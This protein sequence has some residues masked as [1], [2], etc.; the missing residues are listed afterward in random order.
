MRENA[1]V[2]RGGLKC[3]T[4]GRFDV[5]IVDFTSYPRMI[6]SKKYSPERRGSGLMANCCRKSRDARSTFVLIGNSNATVKNGENTL[7]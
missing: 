6:A 2:S 1:Q 4:S 5:V 7:A 3:T